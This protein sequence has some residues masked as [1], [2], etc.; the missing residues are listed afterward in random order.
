MSFYPTELKIVENEQLQI[1]WS[2]G[3]QTTSA[4]RELRAKCPCASCR[5]KRKQD[6]PKTDIL[7]VIAPNE[8]EP[9]RLVG[10]KPVGNY[11]YTLSWNDGHDT[12]IFSFDLL[13]QLG[14]VI[15]TN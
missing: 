1:A 9:L 6:S 5:E 2:D 4:L 13:R 3:I 12:G 8:T 10:M 7:P 11:A 15:P 14:T